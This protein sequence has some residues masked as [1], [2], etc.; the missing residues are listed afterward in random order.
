MRN[1]EQS[2][3]AILEPSTLG[4]AIIEDD[5]PLSSFSDRSD[6]AVAW[7]SPQ[8]LQLIADSEHQSSIDEFP[9]GNAGFLKNNAGGGLES[10]GL[11]NSRKINVCVCLISQRYI[12]SLGVS[13]STQ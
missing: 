13:R 10:A 6:I 8:W 11:S 5:G 12:S 4:I 9:A 1:L 2:A 7:G 3:C